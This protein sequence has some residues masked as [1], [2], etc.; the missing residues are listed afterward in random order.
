[1]IELRQKYG[2]VVDMATMARLLLDPVA[3]KLSGDPSELHRRCVLGRYLE[4]FSH[5]EGVRDD[6][7]PFGHIE[8]VAVFDL[9]NMAVVVFWDESSAA[10]AL[11]RQAKTPSPG[12]F[13]AIPPLDAALPLPGFTD[14]IIKV[15]SVDDRLMMIPTYLQ[16]ALHKRAPATTTLPPRGR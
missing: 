7:A 1:M 5:P 12:W 8:A 9:V 3:R 13:A 10:A 15:G 6:L 14:G 11:Q 4:F 16:V 2:D